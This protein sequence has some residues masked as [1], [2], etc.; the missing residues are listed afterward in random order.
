MILGS[1]WPRDEALWLPVLPDLLREFPDL[2]VVLTPH[3]PEPHRLAQL[4]SDLQA[5]GL[6]H[7]RLSGLM[8]AEPACTSDHPVR[9]VLVD[10]IGVLAEIYRAGRLAYVG[11][12]FTTGVHNTLEPAVTGMPVLFGP[13]IQNAEEAGQLVARGVGFV[14]RRPSE[15]LQRARNLLAN[16]DLLDELGRRARQLVL[17][18]RGAT[19]RSLEIIEPLLP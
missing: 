2:R 10:S 17:D 12:S 15:A 19:G 5:R 16:P 13:V 8:A 7:L 14:L 3:E 6:P 1:T 9:V 4:E 11:G 18:Q